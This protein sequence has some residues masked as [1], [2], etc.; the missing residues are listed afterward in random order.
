MSRVML[1]TGASRGIGAATARLAAQQGYALCL[2]YHQ[3]ADAANA[4]L[5]QVRGRM[6][7]A[8]ASVVVDRVVALLASAAH[9][10]RL[11]KLHRPAAAGSH[12]IGDAGVELLDRFGAVAAPAEEKKTGRLSASPFFL[13]SYLRD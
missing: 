11:A 13:V 10:R 5:D 4:V 12:P 3:R 6:P 7:R 1:I 8:A 9:A 2:N